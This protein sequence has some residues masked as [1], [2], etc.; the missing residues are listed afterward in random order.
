MAGIQSVFSEEK[1]QATYK[2]LTEKIRGFAEKKKYRPYI[3]GE[4]Q[5]ALAA[6]SYMVSLKQF[7][8]DMQQLQAELFRV[9]EKLI[10]II[11]VFCILNECTVE[12]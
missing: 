12:N 11:P 2:N 8:G 4:W 6:P 1:L 3:I 7:I 9:E 10:A 5:L